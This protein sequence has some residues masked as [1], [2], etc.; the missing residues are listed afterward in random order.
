MRQTGSVLGVAATVAFVG[1][2]SPQV[3]DFRLLYVTHVALALI[4]AVLCLR[5]DTAPR[6]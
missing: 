6:S 2:A 3:A 4:T 5:I 1:H